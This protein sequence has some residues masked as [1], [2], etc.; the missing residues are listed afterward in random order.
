MH[1]FQVSTP[2]ETPRDIFEKNIHLWGG[3]KASKYFKSIARKR[4]P[5]VYFSQNIHTWVGKPASS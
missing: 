1:I 2:P 3:E 4:L 5:V